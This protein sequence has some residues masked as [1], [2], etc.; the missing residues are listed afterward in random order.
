M[1]MEVQ[2]ELMR[3]KSGLLIM[4]DIR[5]M[6]RLKPKCEMCIEA[7]EAGGACSE[8]SSRLSGIIIK[9]TFQLLE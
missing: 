2:Q 1:N 8:I 9:E 7:H 6:R 5:H 4:E 3:G